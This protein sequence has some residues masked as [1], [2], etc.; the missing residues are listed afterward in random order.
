MEI[1]RIAGG[2]YGADHADVVDCDGEFRDSN[3]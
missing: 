2:L 3:G 1:A